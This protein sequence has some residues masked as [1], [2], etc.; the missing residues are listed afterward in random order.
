LH[1]G[2]AAMN[3]V[4]AAD[5][6]SIGFTGASK[7]LEGDRGFFRSQSTS[8]DETRITDRLGE[9]WKI[10]E[11]CYKVWGC[12]GHTHSAIDVAND[13][14]AGQRWSGKAAVEHV[15]AIEIETYGPGYEIVKTKNPST[16]FQA[17]FSLAY[18]VAASLIYGGAPPHAFAPE[19]FA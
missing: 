6:A 1:P 11:N 17:K 14:R 15:K 3:G 9:L 18:C 12:C 7:I 4:L 19:H 10:T 8:F 5:L 2:K 16:P 13:M